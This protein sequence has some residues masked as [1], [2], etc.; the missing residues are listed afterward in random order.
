MK[1]VGA[2]YANLSPLEVLR[3]RFWR[4]ITD[5]AQAQWLQA[6]GW[7]RARDGW[8]LPDWHPHKRRRPRPGRIY[9]DADEERREYR[10]VSEPYD[11]RHAANSQVVHG[12]RGTVQTRNTPWHKAPTIPAYRYQ[13]YAATV[14]VVSF[15]VTTTAFTYNTQR[16]QLVF[17]LASS[18]LVCVSFCIA[19]KA[20]RACE[21]E[22]AEAQLAGKKPY[23]EIHR[24]N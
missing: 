1:Q 5:Y 15:L 24:A 16:T 10:K 11:Q 7:R 3:I 22:W 17:V 13:P 23:E 18:L 12:E 6:N 14:T 21:I 20:R 2:P 4:A 8:L 9:R 19:H